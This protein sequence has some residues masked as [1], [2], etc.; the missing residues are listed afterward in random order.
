MITKFNVIANQTFT[1]QN[2]ADYRFGRTY[3]VLGFQADKFGC[4]YAVCEWLGETG[5]KSSHIFY[6]EDFA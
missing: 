1:V 5:T 2:P 4:V 6:A 3:K